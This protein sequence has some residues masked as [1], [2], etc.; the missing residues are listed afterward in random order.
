MCPVEQPV[1]L[2]SVLYGSAVLWKI[3]RDLLVGSVSK[4]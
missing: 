2:D 3:A 1:G 4:E